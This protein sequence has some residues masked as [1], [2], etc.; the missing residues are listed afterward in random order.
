MNER[1][2]ELS[3]VSEA[4]KS[5][6]QLQ[7]MSTLSSLLFSL[8]DIAQNCALLDPQQS[9]GWNKKSRHSG[10]MYTS[11]KQNLLSTKT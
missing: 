3:Q 9:Q 7:D 11:M 10:S 2:R 4:D 6:M 5:T 1:M 8:L